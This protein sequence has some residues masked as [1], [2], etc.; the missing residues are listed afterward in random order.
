MN[1]C[2]DNKHKVFRLVYVSLPTEPKLLVDAYNIQNVAQRNNEKLEVIGMLIYDNGRF[3]QFLEGSKRNVK[4]IFSKIELDSRHHHV[5]VISQN[6]IPQRQFSDWHIRLTFI[7]EIQMRSG[8][9]YKKLFYTKIK[10]EEM[11]D[12]AMESRSLLL[13]FK[14]SCIQ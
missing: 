8:I 14:R 7:S 6:Y 4:K 3:M 10:S 12:R 11:I 1:S 13:S 5:D 2:E 9:I